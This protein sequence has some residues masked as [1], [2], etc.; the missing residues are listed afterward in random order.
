MKYFT[1][2]VNTVL[3]NRKKIVENYGFEN[4][5]NY[6]QNISNKELYDLFNQLNQIFELFHIFVLY[7]I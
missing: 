7:T 2:K 3:N 6:E 1:H 4:N 5:R